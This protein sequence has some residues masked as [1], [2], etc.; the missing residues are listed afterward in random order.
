MDA[1]VAVIGVGTIGSMTM[2]RLAELGVEAIG[3]ER[4][5]PGHDRGAAG[6]NTRLF[7][8]AYME[9]AQYVP[10]LKQSLGLW[11]ELSEQTATQLLVQCGGLSIGRP[12]DASMQQVAESAS[13]YGLKLQ[14][15]QQAEMAEKY[16]Q[17]VLDEG[18]L[19]YFDPEAGFLRS[20]QAVV[21]AAARAESLGARILRYHRVERVEPTRDGV[22]IEA[23]GSTWRVRTAILALGSWAPP[24]LPSPPAHSVSPKRVLLT[25]FAPKSVQDFEPEVFPVFTR[26]SGSDFLYG[27][28]TADHASVK[29]CGLRPTDIDDPDRFERR[30]DPVELARMV[31]LLRAHVSGLHPDPVRSAGFTDLYSSDGHGI[32][33][34]HPQT[35]NIVLAGAYSGRGFK[36][37]PAVGDA[38]ARLAVG[39]AVPEIAFMRPERFATRGSH[40]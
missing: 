5:A 22:V 40:R 35:P 2:W 3:F 34:H 25:W 8:L 14:I 28:P 13:S 21:T 24:L 9:G 19:A 7:R 38:V 32:T 29:V 18:E 36:F 37:A 12:Q 33:G 4:F 23:E 6:G 16:P 31:E 1:D 20:E 15:L 39:E 26:Q 10:L 30:H 27:A 11:R 17:H